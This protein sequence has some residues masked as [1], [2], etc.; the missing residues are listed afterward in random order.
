MNNFTVK[1][2][3]AILAFTLTFMF[4]FAVF[5]PRET[6]SNY[7]TLK[8]W[9]EFSF[10]DLFSGK[11]F[12]GISDYFSDTIFGRDTFV[13]FESK[14]NAL[15]GL[16]EEEKI[17]TIKPEESDPDQ[18][19][20]ES[21]ESSTEA[22]DSSV[23]SDINSDYSSEAPENSFVPDESEPEVSTPTEESKPDES[24][25]EQGGGLAEISGSILIIGNRAMEIYYG[26]EKGAVRYANILN[27]FAETVDP[28]VNVYSMVIPKS[29]AYYLSQATQEKYQ[30]LAIRNKNNIDTISN[31]LNDKVIDVNIYDILGRHSNEEIYAR[32]D[33]HWTALGAYYASSVFAEKA[34]TAFDDISEFEE[35]RRPGYLGTYYYVYSSKDNNSVLQQKPEDFL[36]YIPDTKY[37]TEYYSSSGFSNEP[38][39][40]DRLSEHNGFFFEISDKKIGSW[41]STFILGDTYCVK[42]KSEECKNGR[43]LLIVKD[44]YGNAL[45]P[46]MI[47]GFEEIY[48]VDARKYTK[49]LKE[50]INEFGITDVLFAEC[51]FSAVGGEYLNSLEELCK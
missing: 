27:S 44:S 43:K 42:A 47:E 18:D 49:N 5:L 21:V 26:N 37:T 24:Q 20:S 38:I 22:E 8:E 28:S 1:I 11:Y 39:D 3:A 30:K 48:I 12:K 17:I 29:S 32:T 25:P 34:G 35:V 6:E 16:E 36:S 40:E 31:T 15:Y 41:Y 9:P 46:F 45:A 10:E 23:E 7:T 50:T 14:I 33:H 13:D 51:T 4:V 2:C 19:Q